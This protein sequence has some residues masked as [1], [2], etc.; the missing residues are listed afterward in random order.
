VLLK[1]STLAVT[2]LLLALP[3]GAHAAFPG[4]NGKTAFQS[5]RDGTFRIY[6]ATPDGSGDSTALSL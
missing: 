6:T 2:L 3:A 4:E 1:R 5:D